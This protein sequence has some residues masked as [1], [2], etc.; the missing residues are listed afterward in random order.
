MKGQLAPQV[1]L[2]IIAPNP[3]SPR[4]PKQ[5]DLSRKTHSLPAVAFLS[6][7]SRKHSIPCAELP[8]KCT[9]IFI[10]LLISL[11]SRK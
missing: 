10:D 3:I 9:D 4:V 7:S 5:P 1:L 11:A 8:Y 2:D 6:F